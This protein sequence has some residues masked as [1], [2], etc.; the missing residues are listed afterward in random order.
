MSSFIDTFKIP[1]RGI[2][3]ATAQRSLDRAKE[4]LG[5]IRY[6]VIRT[7]K[8]QGQATVTYGVNGRQSLLDAG[9]LA[10]ELNN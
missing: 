5:D 10:F 8:N 4:Q 3:V 9:A 1:V 2:A 6:G 7:E